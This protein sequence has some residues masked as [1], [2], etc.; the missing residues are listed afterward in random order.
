MDRPPEFVTAFAS[1]DRARLTRMNEA[2]RST[3]LDARQLLRQYVEALWQDV[4]RSGER[5]DVGEKY[6]ALAIVRELTRSLATVAF[7]AVH[8]NRSP[9]GPGPGG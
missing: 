2:A 1:L 4:Q 5:P 9:L 7:D 3:Q 8:D 6:Q